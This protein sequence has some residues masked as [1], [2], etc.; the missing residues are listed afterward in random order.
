MNS[1]TTSCK[2]IGLLTALA[3][4]AYLVPISTNGAWFLLAPFAAICSYLAG[5]HVVSLLYGVLAFVAG[6]LAASLTLIFSA[7]ISLLTFAL[8][9]LTG[10]V[11]FALLPWWIGRARRNTVMFKAQEREHAVVQAEL[12]E[13]AR[14][15]E[16]MHDQL[17]HDLALLA[18]STGGLQVTL[19]KGTAAYARAVEIREQADGAIDHLHQIIGV[20]H[21]SSEQAP[22]DP[23]PLSVERLLEQARSMGLKINFT[24]QGPALTGQWVA[25]AY[26]TVHRILQETLTNAAKY[27]PHEVLDIVLD[28]RANPLAL[29]VS[30]PLPGRTP[31]DRAGATGLESLR[32]TLEVA[33]G[34]LQIRRSNQRFE[35]LASIAR[36]DQ[37]A[38]GNA[39]QV[40]V[41]KHIRLMVFLPFATVLAMTAGLYLLQDATNRATALNPHDYQQLRVGMNRAEVAEIVHAK[42]LDEPLP[43][44]RETAKPAQAQCRYYAA[45][46]EILD[47]GSEMFRLCF[48]EDVLVSADHLYPDS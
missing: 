6:S 1:M 40:P 41:K 48:T 22:L 18:L 28:T 46:T 45:R 7:H 39:A 8:N 4:C 25:G 5:R 16:A 26:R 15:A 20:L 37:P 19:E 14:I 34:S 47:L 31:A 24:R 13:R 35:V 43:V 44:I 29:T 32:R 12:R 21:D 2:Q 17:G 30:N 36:Q 27:A 38:P 23:A 3:L 11:L 9:I 42:G 10:L 33:G